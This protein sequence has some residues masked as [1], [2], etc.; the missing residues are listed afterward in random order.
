[1]QEHERKVNSSLAKKAPGDVV[2][3]K[4][5]EMAKQNA[6][7]GHSLFQG[8]IDNFSRMNPDKLRDL[9]KKMSAET[10]SFITKS[11]NFQYLSPAAK[12]AVIE[13]AGKYR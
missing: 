4:P 9:K 12:A 6:S 2:K 10:A 8:I 3:M 1:M 7:G 5:N 13:A 11:D